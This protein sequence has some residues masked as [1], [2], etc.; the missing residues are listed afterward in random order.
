MM[1]RERLDDRLEKGILGLITLIL[2]AGPLLFGSVRVRDELILTGLTIAALGLW[3]VRFWIRSDYRILW[4]PF[5]WAVLAFVAYAIWRYAT[6]EVEYVARLDLNRVI[7][8][9]AIF[10]LILDNLNRQEWTQFLV[11]VL[12]AV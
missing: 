10:F 4:P 7:L 9:T 8:Y 11:F 5:A 3:L 12:I 6:A 1:D 2:I